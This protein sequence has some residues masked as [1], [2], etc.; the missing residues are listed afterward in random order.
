MKSLEEWKELNSQVVALYQQGWYS[1]AASI[2]EEALKFAENTFG[3][4]H[5]NVAESLNN[6]GLIYYSQGRDVHRVLSKWRLST[7]KGKPS[8]PDRLDASQAMNKTV[9]KNLTKQKYAEAESMFKRALAIRE[10]AFWTDHPDVLQSL[11]NLAEVYNAQGKYAEAESLL[12][13]LRLRK[14]EQINEDLTE[15]CVFRESVRCISH[16]RVKLAKA[17]VEPWIEGMTENL[18][19]KGTFIKTGDYRAFEINGEVSVTIFLPS[20]LSDRG[21]A[22]GIEA[23]GTITRVDDGNEGVAVSFAKNVREFKRLLN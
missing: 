3:H 19:E 20:L 11:G 5:P 6:L 21:E 9:L 8:G 15:V 14:A 4:K 12:K 1:G 17:G 16:F 18:S 7:S 10:K 23:V 2:A 22:V 13:R